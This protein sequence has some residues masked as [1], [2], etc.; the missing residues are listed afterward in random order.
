MKLAG[1]ALIA[2]LAVAAP[3]TAW[4]E[5]LFSV[6]DSGVSEHGARL[7]VEFS[8]CEEAG[9]TVC[10]SVVAVFGT[11]EDE[12]LGQRVVWDMA[13]SGGGFWQDGKLWDVESH[14]VFNAKMVL[15]QDV[16]SIKGCVGFIC[17]NHNWERVVVQ[18]P[19]N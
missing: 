1:L 10:G 5:E 13:P 6:W 2:S 8:L 17:R 19:A 11:A 14:K 12:L 15:R 3:A 16:L 9:E 4:A 18:G 7:H